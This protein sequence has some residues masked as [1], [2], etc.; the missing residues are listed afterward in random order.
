MRAFLAVA[1]LAL[2]ALAVPASGEWVGHCVA[3]DACSG[4]DA[5]EDQTCAY[6][7]QGRGSALVVCTDGHHV[8]VT[9]CEAGS[10]CRQLL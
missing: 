2:T 9:R 8:S 6:N 10:G 1:L 3:Q 7:G 5:G 4:V